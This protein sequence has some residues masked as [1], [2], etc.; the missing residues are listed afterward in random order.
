M[1]AADAL[2]KDAGSGSI[3][4]HEGIIVGVKRYSYLITFLVAPKLKKKQHHKRYSNLITFLVAP[5]QCS[6]ERREASPQCKKQR[7]RRA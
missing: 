1:Y 6:W 7:L 5:K 3:C 4:R 2:C